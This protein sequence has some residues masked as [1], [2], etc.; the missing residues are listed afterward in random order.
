MI[1]LD[2]LA[3]IRTFVSLMPPNLIIIAL[4]LKD[5]VFM[6]FRKENPSI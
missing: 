3:A 6:V 2:D 4:G 1:R 5:D